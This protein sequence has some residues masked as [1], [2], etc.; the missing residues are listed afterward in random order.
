[1]PGVRRLAAEAYVLFGKVPASYLFL[2]E[3]VAGLRRPGRLA[4]LM[5]DAR[6]RAAHSSKLSIASWLLQIYKDARGP[7]NA[8]IRCAGGKRYRRSRL[9]KLP[10]ALH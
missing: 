7:S 9:N 10:W 1:M 8:L 3:P 6:S 5:E 4:P 2:I